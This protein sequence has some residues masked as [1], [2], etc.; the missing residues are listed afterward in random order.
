LA[1]CVWSLR[2]VH[3]PLAEIAGGHRQGV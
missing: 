2:A 3:R 1:V